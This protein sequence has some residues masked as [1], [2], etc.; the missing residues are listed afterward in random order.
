MV[1]LGRKEA[2]LAETKSQ[3]PRNSSTSCSIHAV[4][5]T[6][7]KSMMDIAA[8]V[9]AWD[10][11]V[12]NAGDLSAPAPIAQTSVDDWWQSFEVRIP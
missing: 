6:D 4:S 5:V 8:P 9:G 1:L 3:M 2:A 10:I 12:L 11:L 7:E